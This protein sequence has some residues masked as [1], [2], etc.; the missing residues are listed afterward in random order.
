MDLTTLTAIPARKLALGLGGA[1]AVLL[2]CLASA[3]S[4]YRHGHA[5]AKAEGDTALAELRQAEATAWA[6]SKAKALDRYVAATQRADQT[7]ADYLAARQRL[8]QT[9]TLITKEIPHA[10]AGLAACAFGPDFV[11]VYNQALGLGG[12]GVPEA[13]NSGGAATDPAAPAAADAGLR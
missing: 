8:A 7:A 11:R 2:L 13:A 1:L 9:R 5:T 10:T 6:E 4:G 12:P 3:W